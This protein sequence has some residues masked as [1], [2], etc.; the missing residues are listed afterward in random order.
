MDDSERV[1]E[2]EITPFLAEEIDAKNFIC[3]RY[4]KKELFNLDD[5]SSFLVENGKFHTLKVHIH[6][7]DLFG[8]KVNIET[9]FESDGGKEIEWLIYLNGDEIQ[10]EVINLEETNRVS[11]SFEPP[12]AAFNLSQTGVTD[13]KAVAH[14]T[15]SVELDHN[16]ATITNT[17]LNTE[18]FYLDRVILNGGDSISLGTLANVIENTGTKRFEYAPT[19]PVA[20]RELMFL[21]GS[22]EAMFYYLRQESRYK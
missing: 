12:L 20:T 7:R 15:T 18:I 13:S 6:H 22:P 10:K 2:K 9:T 5:G 21:K 4:G 19:H 1:S 16:K 11:F 14:T 8:V 3:Y 17:D